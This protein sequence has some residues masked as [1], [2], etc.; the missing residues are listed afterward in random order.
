MKDS[1]IIVGADMGGY[2]NFYAITPNPMK[3]KLLCRIIHYNKD[4]EL[5][6]NGKLAFP[7]RGMDYHPSERML[8]TG[9]EMGFIV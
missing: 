8:Y 5:S 2:L 9:D 7:I 6:G 4:E 3:N 1:D